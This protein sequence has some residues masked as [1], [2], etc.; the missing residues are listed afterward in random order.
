MEEYFSLVLIQIFIYI[1]IG[2][3]VYISKVLPGLK[4]ILK[5]NSPSMMPSVQKKHMNQYVTELDKNNL[6]PWYYFHLKYN[7]FITVFLA[8][9]VIF[10][11]VLVL[12]DFKLII[13]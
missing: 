10:L 9:Q 7:A 5:N 3:Y 6:K 4:F 2:N 13:F 12:L 11:I 8:I 1:I